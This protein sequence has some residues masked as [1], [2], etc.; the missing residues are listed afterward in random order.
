MIKGFL[1]GFLSANENDVLPVIRSYSNSIYATL[2]L[3]TIGVVR[4]IFYDKP[5]KFKSEKATLFDSIRLLRIV[6]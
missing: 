1:L 3:A 5:P 2:F 6:N 4:N